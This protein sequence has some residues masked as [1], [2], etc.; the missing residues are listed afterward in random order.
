MKKNNQQLIFGI[1]ACVAALNNSKRVIYEII[2]TK[3]V[4]IKYKDL[5]KK[6]NI[7]NVLIKKG[8]K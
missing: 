1:H 4:F 8:A 3:Q 5:I 2:C 7:K 6:K